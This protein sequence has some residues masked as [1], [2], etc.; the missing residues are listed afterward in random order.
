MVDQRIANVRIVEGVLE[1]SL[2]S[3]TITDHQYDLGF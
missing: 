2:S 1:L 3:S